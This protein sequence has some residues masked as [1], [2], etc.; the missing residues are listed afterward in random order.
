VGVERR[1]RRVDR[2]LDRGVDHLRDQHEG[3]REEER[4]ELVVVHPRGEGDDQDD[5][6]DEEV[7]AHVALGPQHVDDALEGVVEAVEERR[8]AARSAHRA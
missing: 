6:G 1:R 4:D 8:R 7:D 3:D 2:A 5:D